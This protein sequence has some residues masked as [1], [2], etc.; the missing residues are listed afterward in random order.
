MTPHA[1]YAIGLIMLAI[2]VG[3]GVLLYK[4]REEPVEAVAPTVP[5]VPTVPGEWGEWKLIPSTTPKCGTGLQSYARTCIG[6]G[7]V[8]DDKKTESYDTGIG[9]PIYG[10]YV[11]LERIQDSIDAGYGG[12][13]INVQEI[14]VYSPSGENLIGSTAI[15]TAGS[16]YPNWIS[17]TGYVIDG[18]LDT[19]AST[20]VTSDHSKAWFKIDMGADVNI[21]AV[22]IVNRRDCCRGRL[23]GTRIRVLNAAED[24]VYTSPMITA[25]DTVDQ[26]VMFKLI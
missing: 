26:M 10:R 18:N 6:E 1:K 21:G 13:I 25:A 7:C 9:C 5:A 23:V 16:E 20:D 11:I 19:I 3:V 2:I 8:G 4:K 14:N 17:R 15:A 22:R 12:Q 24:V